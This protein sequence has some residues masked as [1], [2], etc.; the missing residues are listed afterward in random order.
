MLIPPKT[1]TTAQIDYLT[2]SGKHGYRTTHDI[3]QG[4][5]G[6]TPEPG[7]PL[8][9]FEH[10]LRFSSQ[11]IDL[12]SVHPTDADRVF[13]V[14]PGTACQV[15]GDALRRTACDLL[16]ATDGRFNRID[17]CVD[18][19]SPEGHTFEDVFDELEP[20]CRAG[21]LVGESDRIWAGQKGTTC[22][23]GSTESDRLFRIYDK[24]REQG[25]EPNTW[26]RF[27]AQFRRE[28]AH[29]M[30]EDM[31]RTQDWTKFAQ[32][33]T[34]GCFPQFETQF[35]DLAKVLFDQPA[36]RPTMQQ[37]IADLDNW[38]KAVQ[39][40]F[41]GR[42]QM[43]AQMSGLDPYEVARRLDLFETKPTKR[44]A[45][46]SGFLACAMARLFDIVK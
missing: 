39:H 22:Y 20:V 10:R 11:A 32:A 2:I 8:H 7:K 13:V 46:H 37:Q 26:I 6:D 15:Q 38:V 9:G 16:D 18:L 23:F 42:V 28:V 3:L 41:G 21:S 31:Y 44:L 36:Y 33:A 30:T 35:P 24:G 1:T 25:L 17:T 27:E 5:T 29:A 43:L 34:R 40:Q 19:R 45:R 4:A 12:C 14:L